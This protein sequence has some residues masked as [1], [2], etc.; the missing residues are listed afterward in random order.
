MLSFAWSFPRPHMTH[1]AVIAGA[2]LKPE[3]SLY[4]KCLSMSIS[5]LLRVLDNQAPRKIQSGPISDRA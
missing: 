3:Q 5:A 4:Q 1:I 2:A